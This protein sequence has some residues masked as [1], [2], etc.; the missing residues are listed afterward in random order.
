[1]YPIYSA[2][3]LDAT[4][5][6]P[7]A[8][9]KGQQVQVVTR[10][11]T[12]PYPIFNA[13]S[14]PIASSLVTVTESAS[15][16]TVYIDTDTPE[17]VYLDWYDAGT[18]Q[19][20]PI[21]FEEVSRQSAMASAAS[22]ATSATSA[23]ASAASAATTAADFA[24]VRGWVERGVSRRNLAPDPRLTTTTMTLN[25][26][27]ATDTRPATDG[28]DAG[29]YM[30]RTITSPNTASPMS[31]P[32]TG[33]G[34]NAIPVV[35][36][37]EILTSWYAR[38]SAGGPA[39]RVD[40]N[41]YD[42][43]GAALSSTPS[44]TGAS[45]SITST[46]VRHSQ[47]NTVPAGAFYGQ[48]RLVWTGTALVDQTLD[49]AM[50]L[51]EVGGVQQSWF[52]G[53]TPS[54][55]SVGYGW[56]GVR[57]ASVSRR[58]DMR[59]VRSIKTATGVLLPDASGSIDLS[60]VGGGGVSAHSA[61][62]GL[63]ADDHPQYLNPT[64]GDARYFTQAQVTA[65]IAAAVASSSTGD[66]A[67]ANHTG[68]QGMGTIDGLSAALTSRPQ[69][70]VVVNG[71]EARPSGS[72]VVFWVGGG[73]QPVNMGANDVWLAGAAVTPGDTTPPTAPT[74]LAA[75]GVA[76]TSL[77]LTWT[78]ATDNVGVTGYRV[79]Q[80]GVILSGTTGTLSRLITGLT[81]S[82][83][84]DFE[85]GARD[86]N[87]NW[88][89]WSSAVT[90]TTAASSDT[91][92]PTV[93]TD[94]SASS[95]TAS[96]FTLTWTASTDAVG[97]TGYRVLIDGV[98]YA[99][100]TDTSQVVTGRVASTAYD[101]TVQARD[102]AGNWS[103]ESS[104]I[105]VT[106]SA[107]G[108]LPTHSVFATPPGALVKTT[109]ASPYEHATGFY[110]YTS[111]ANGWKVKGARLYVPNGI[112]VPTSCEV[113]LYAPGS[114]TPTLGTP[115]KTATMTGITANAWNTV[116]FPSV[117]EVTPGVP[118]WIGIKFADGTWL[119]VTAFG[120]SFVGASD[121]STLVLADRVPNVGLDRN[122]RRIG[123][124]STVALTG[125]G[126]RDVWFGMDVIVEEA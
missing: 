44:S 31:M 117:T 39:A 22:S 12:T 91:T 88:S 21:W 120:E 92:P 38:K 75:T 116:N 46:W 108:S 107:G 14:D 48:P 113:N 63:G 52:S 60:S 114:G 30:R 85:V 112:S 81:A 9:L 50:A 111:G 17:T 80:D 10:N 35:A 40:W 121:G 89:A 101:I 70:Q 8:A 41:W 28:P 73:T 55:D 99:L 56:E 54:T 87:G 7:N 105:T 125:G 67:R 83:E 72:D 122:Y 45:K 82:T 24:A 11:T 106:T 71:S 103:A 42:A 13:A 66:R 126:E 29:S 18:G 76:A 68:T 69:I 96:G 115:T 16:P 33:S 86:A 109:E 1:M 79:R 123:T 37:Q 119:G 19:R 27:T 23:A 62:S 118:F 93:P 53:D 49:L 2:W 20:G 90:V 78:A 100:P 5:L 34:L 15:T 124:G 110:T 95:I 77:T 65:A 74:G 97:V 102:A 104:E 51:V 47:A 84:Y 59:L 57:N 26:A 36:G 94:L 4:T 6:L 43:A 25:G 61:L 58:I 3:V 32:L 98:Q 64:R